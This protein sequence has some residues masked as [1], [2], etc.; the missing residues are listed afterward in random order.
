LAKGADYRQLSILSLEHLTLTTLW[1]SHA[2]GGLTSPFLLW[3]A[4]VPILAF[5]Y[6]APDRRLWLVLI[7]MLAGNLAL[8]AGA[9]LLIDPMPAP[10][11]EQVRWL[12]AVSLLAAFAYVSMM[13]V[14]FGRVL[15]S[16]DEMASQAERH[17]ATAVALDQKARDLRS[18][19]A[20]KA[21]SLARI[22]RECRSPLD[23][24]LSSSRTMLEVE[25][26]EQGEG[27]SP[28]L[29]SIDEAARHLS[30]VVRSIETVLSTNQ[31][32]G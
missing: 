6:C 23:E 4:V 14:Y 5:L 2:Y 16:R 9:T 25:A 19:G 18:L 30:E 32:P 8:F 13:A 12:A 28:D 7:A 15:D 20:T 17:L 26:R 10:S 1:A 24:I 22:V 31:N 29:R 21:T 3:L 27:E 11:S